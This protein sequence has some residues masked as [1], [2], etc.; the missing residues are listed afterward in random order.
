MDKLAIAV[1]PPE[2][3]IICSD[4][5]A[6]TFYGSFRENLFFEAFLSQ[7]QGGIALQN[8]KNEVQAEYGNQAGCAIRAS[9]NYNYIRELSN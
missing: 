3:R 9:S 4:A 2:L 8:Y 6:A 7:Y 1:L 5:C